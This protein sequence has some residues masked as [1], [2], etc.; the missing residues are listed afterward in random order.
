MRHRSWKPHCR[1]RALSGRGAP[2]SVSAHIHK[3]FA[4]FGARGAVF[5]R[6]DAAEGRFKKRSCLN[7]QAANNLAYVLSKA[8]KPVCL[9]VGVNNANV[10]NNVLLLMKSL[11][12]SLRKQ[13]ETC[14]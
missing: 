2:A 4:F 10:A 14:C 7:A 1:F 6:P 11:L 13:N 9:R 8:G 3:S 5:W 12:T